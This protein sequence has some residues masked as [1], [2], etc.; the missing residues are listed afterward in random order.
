MNTTKPKFVYVTLIKTTP[1]KLW[2]AL[3]SPEF[4]RQYW[5]GTSLESDWKVGSEMVYRRNGELN[6]DGR[7]LKSEPPRLL[8]YTFHSVAE[9]IKDEQPSRVTF[10]IEPLDAK[11]GTSDSTVK[12][13][14]THDNFPQESKVFP[15]ISG[16]WPTVL[17]S[18]KSLLE[19]GKALE[20]TKTSCDERNA[21][22]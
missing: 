8:S 10:E 18:L 6:V 7:V 11:P 15:M 16:G 3:T 2:T 19:T 5:M 4:T 14:V 21:K 9:E 12:L 13:T 22:H 1:E 20:I 17:S